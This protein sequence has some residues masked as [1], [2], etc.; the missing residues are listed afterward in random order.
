MFDIEYSFSNDEITYYN[1]EVTVQVQTHLLL[2]KQSN[3]IIKTKS[4]VKIK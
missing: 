4:D 1:R 2:K 3:I